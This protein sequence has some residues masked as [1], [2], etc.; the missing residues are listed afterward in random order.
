MLEENARTLSNVTLANG[1]R[2]R[3]VRMPM[4]T[5]RYG[6]FRTYVNSQFINGV[7]MIPVYSD[8]DRYEAEALRIWKQVLPSYRHVPI[9]S[10]ELITWAGAIHCILMEVPAGTWSK[11]QADPASICSTSACY[12]S[13]TSGNAGCDSVPVSGSCSGGE[14]RWC[15][16]GEV[17]ANTCRGNACGWKGELG[18]N[19]CLQ[20]VTSSSTPPP[21]TTP[22]PSS[23][24][25]AIKVSARPLR[26]IP[27]N[28]SRGLS[29][30]IDVTGSGRVTALNVSVHIS[31]TYRGDLAVKLSHAGRTVTIREPAGGSYDNLT[32]DLSVDAFAGL[33]VDGGWT[34][35]VIDNAGQDVGTLDAWSLEIS[36]G[37]GSGSVTAPPS[38][39]SGQREFSST[40]GKSIPD[41]SDRGVT[42]AIR[43]GERFTTD[44][45]M[46]AVDIRHT[47]RAD[48]YVT[49]TH[50]GESVLLHD[51]TGGSA[52]DLRATYE[53]GNFAG[54]AANGDWTLTVIDTAAQDTGK[55]MSWNLLF[56]QPTSTTP[57]AGWRTATSSS[58]PRSA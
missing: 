19:A 42:D 8:D 58:T 43:V 13:S 33:A 4:P 27:D 25:D 9:D 18:H 17:Q 52:D 12:P 55:I 50:D 35:T 32:L 7:N 40:P 48:L 26:A 31:H 22:P 57:A 30:T 45:V 51:R 23:T 47:Y 28:D 38:G 46:V 11:F 3:V 44:T 56:R 1:Q 34:L 24:S 49:L 29:S 20:G 16:S 39:S 6:N 41:D 54:E 21:T 53:V 14:A 36:G 2:L 15:D 37:S 5:N 10:T